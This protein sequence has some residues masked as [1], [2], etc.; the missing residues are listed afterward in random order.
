MSII[1]VMMLGK[2]MKR[3]KLIDSYPCDLCSERAK[4]K[5]EDDYDPHKFILI[6]DL[7]NNENDLAKALCAKRFPQHTI[8]SMLWS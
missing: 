6:C 1:M 2:K 7:H 4:T 3:I 5:Y 8:Q